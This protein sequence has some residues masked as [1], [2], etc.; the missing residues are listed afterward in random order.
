MGSFEE[1]YE[2]VIRDIEE[3]E[4]RF[5]SK[6]KPNEIRLPRLVLDIKDARWISSRF[7]EDVERGIY[8]VKLNV[9]KSPNSVEMEAT[10]RII[11]GVG[12][13]VVG[14]TVL[15]VLKEVKDYLVRNRRKREKLRRQREKI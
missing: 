14:A 3:L 5:Q 7:Y 2:Q 13:T 15:F 12:Q 11:E 4:I 1:H 9:K 10:L 8:S 6:N